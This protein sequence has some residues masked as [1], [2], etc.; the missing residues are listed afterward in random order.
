MFHLLLTL[1][2]VFAAI[3]HAK[4]N[5]WRE[6]FPTIYYASFFNVYYQYISF[7][8]KKLWELKQPFISAFITDA[9]YTFILFPCLIMVFLSN[10]P[11][12]K[13]KVFLRY[14]KWIVI[15]LLIE[16][17]AIK[18]GYIQFKNG[19]SLAWEFFFYPVMYIMIRLHHKRPLLALGVSGIIVLFFLIVFDYEFL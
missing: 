4:W 13:H 14:V 9:L 18:L 8:M 1:F 3:K 15:S 2:A 19:W 6:Y 5:R 11:N 17:I 12:E 16:I 7:S 10:Y